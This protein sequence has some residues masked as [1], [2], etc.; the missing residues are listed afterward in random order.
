MQYVLACSALPMVHSPSRGYIVQHKIILLH[1]AKNDHGDASSRRGSINY[2]SR[3]GIRAILPHG[4]IYHHN[5][6]RRPC[7][8]VKEAFSSYLFFSFHSMSSLCFH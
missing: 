1:T 5:E 8:R 6:I 3:V 2:C 7:R 4:P